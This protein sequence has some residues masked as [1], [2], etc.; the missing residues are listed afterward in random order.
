MDIHRVRFV[1][2]DPQPIHCLRFYEG[3]S[4]SLKLAVSRGDGSIEIWTSSDGE[5]F[6]KDV[7]VPG[8]ADF[9]IEALVWCAGRL[10]S[11]GLTGRSAYNL[12]VCLLCVILMTD[13]HVY[14]CILFLSI[15]TIQEWDLMRLKPSASLDAAGGAVWC[16]EA[17]PDSSTLAAGCEDG[18]VCVHVA[19]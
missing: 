4:S 1:E 12:R 2:Y 19:S 15:G 14:A 8:R 11:A 13:E 7:W 6:F 9:S 5:S 17:S 3:S 16:M 10:F 18:R